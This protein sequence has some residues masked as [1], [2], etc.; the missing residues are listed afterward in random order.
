MTR[1]D[2]PALDSLDTMADPA[3]WPAYL[4]LP[5]FRDRDPSDPDIGLMFDAFGFA[6]WAG[7]SATVFLGSLIK[8]PT[9]AEE[10]L[11]E[12]RETFDTLGELL[13]AGW[14]IESVLALVRSNAP[15]QPVT[16]P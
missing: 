16:L 1:E 9:T 2:D 12:R 11:A 4:F 10:L 5:V 14:R 7:F 8:L 6:G 3:T 13:D 15:Q